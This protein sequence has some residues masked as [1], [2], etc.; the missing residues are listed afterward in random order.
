MEKGL[1]GAREKREEEI[2]SIK[3]RNASPPRKC[4]RHS[5]IDMFTVIEPFL[6]AVSPN[7]E[8]TIFRS[9]PSHGPRF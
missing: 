8:I 9:K 4:A 7:I 5:S 3:T 6:F 2:V 1:R